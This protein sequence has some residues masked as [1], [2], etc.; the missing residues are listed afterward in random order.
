MS[1]KFYTVEKIHELLTK[2]DA[3]II[4]Y[5][6]TLSNSKG[7]SIYNNYSELPNNLTEDTVAYCENDYVDN[8][9]VDNPII[10]TKGF[11]FYNSL[12]WELINKGSSG[13]KVYDDYSYLPT[14]SIEGVSIVI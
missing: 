12:N 6:S 2:Y 11:Y 7:I 13:I 10:Y 4:S 8:T 1:N 5:I 14:E 9:D 3:S